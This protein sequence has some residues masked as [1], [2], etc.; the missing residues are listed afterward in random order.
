MNNEGGLGVD[1]PSPFL[2]ILLP[3]VNLPARKPRRWVRLQTV[4][5][6]SIPIRV[7]STVRLPDCQQGKSLI[8]GRIAGGKQSVTILFFALLLRTRDGLIVSG[9]QL[10]AMG[11][12]MAILGDF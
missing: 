8:A 7:I 6:P 10:M 12:S 3:N 5:E 2:F 11:F 9:Q 4:W 1:S